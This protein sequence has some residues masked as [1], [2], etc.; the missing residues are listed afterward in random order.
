MLLCVIMCMLGN[1]TI[2][3]MGSKRIAAV[4]GGR[5]MALGKGSLCA[6]KLGCRCCMWLSAGDVLNY[7]EGRRRS[8]SSSRSRFQNFET[9]KSNVR[10]NVT[11]PQPDET[12]QTLASSKGS[13]SFVLRTRVQPRC[14][15]S[16]PPASRLSACLFIVGRQHIISSSTSWKSNA[17]KRG[18]GITS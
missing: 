1:E 18:S 7:L 11:I 5:W 4:N 16:S 10:Q 6:I 3:A 13:L 12:I 17:V 15:A 8:S 2:D 9:K 14:V